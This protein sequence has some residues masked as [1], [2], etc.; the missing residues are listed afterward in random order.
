[1][2]VLLEPAT[3]L[4]IILVGY[5]FKRFGLF[6]PLDYRVLQTI[7]FDLVLPGAIIYSFATNPHNP[8]RFWSRPSLSSPR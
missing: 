4:G 5:L 6:R 8:S 2:G 3:L 7:V 1:M